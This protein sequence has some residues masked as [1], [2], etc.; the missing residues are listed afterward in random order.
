MNRRAFLR[1]GTIAGTSLSAVQSRRFA[2]AAAAPSAPTSPRTDEFEPL[3]RTPVEGAAE[4]VVGDD[5]TVAYLAA[6]NGFVTVDVSDPAEPTILA[7]ERQLEIDDRR[8]TEILDVKV[9]GDRLVVP[10]PANR[11]QGDVFQGFLLYDV[12][13]PAEP[14]S[15]GDPVET[16]YHI[17]NC[18]LDGDV[19]YVV[20][21]GSEDHPDS[22]D[23]NRL[24]VFDV[25]DDEIER[26][27]SWS[28]L[29]REPEWRE[30]S[31]FARY[32][33]DVYVHDDV[34]YLA[35]WNAGTFLLDV[36][37]PADPKYL[38]HVRDTD[39]EEQ[40]AIDDDTEAQQGLPGN[41]HYSAV[42]DAGELMAVGREAWE[43]G[44]DEPDGPGGIDL[45]DVSDPADPAHV[46]SI[47]APE[48]EDASYH[49][50]EWT[51]A[52]NFELRN[53]LLHASWYQGGVSIHDVSD[54][55][56]PVEL[57][58]WEDR[59]LAAF[60]TARVAEP[61][62]TIVASSTEMISAYV[63]ADPEG[64]LYTFPIVDPTDDED[65]GDDGGGATSGSDPIPG[66]AGA[67]GVAGLAGGVLGLE[68][69]RRRR[70]EG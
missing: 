16:G 42:D 7:E 26:I 9:D 25:S 49:D 35:H 31:W 3:G 47:A 18:Y 8:L 70:N 43:T 11:T 34:A 48:A 65:E 41:D 36:A 55:A 13:D 53:D 14:V 2:P 60:W 12:S 5:G 29:D 68:W 17:H 10:G 69:F 32:L 39:L 38:S 1:R 23:E 57:V 61:G 37:D 52:H 56:D 30:V 27:G 54:P 50:G 21:N 46:S 6:T 45:Y 63:E 44:G 40:R 20:V 67:V 33:H 51:T 64:A 19:L 59:E 15:V 28:H 66:F 58:R 62:E 4:A 24:D 22:P